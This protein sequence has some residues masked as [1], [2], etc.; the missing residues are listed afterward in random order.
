MVAAAQANR[1]A[2]KAKV[3]TG[4][5]VAEDISIA[6][7]ADIT[8]AISRS[9]QEKRLGLARLRVDKS[10]NSMD[11]FDV[12]LSQNFAHGQFVRQSTRLPS[13][14]DELLK[15]FVERR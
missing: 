7:T 3:V 12:L 14:Y 9:D 13:N 15:D 5:H 2:G 4:Q 11:G 8:L 10:R 1:E 6:Q